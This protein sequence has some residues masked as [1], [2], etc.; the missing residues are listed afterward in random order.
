MCCARFVYRTRSFV[1]AGL[2]LAFAM[3]RLIRTESQLRPKGSPYLYNCK[4]SNVNVGHLLTT[5][6]RK[7]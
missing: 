3:G 4:Q 6:A 7:K 5:A 1:I 2:S